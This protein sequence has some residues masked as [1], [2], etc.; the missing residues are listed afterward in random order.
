MCT[1]LESSPQTS[2]LWASPEVLLTMIHLEAEFVDAVDYKA[3]DAY[4]LGCLLVY[5]LTGKAPFGV[6]E[7]EKQKRG[8]T[9]DS[10]ILAV[11]RGK[12]RALVRMLKLAI[13]ICCS[14]NQQSSS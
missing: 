13:E 2:W 4:G 3:Q 11:Y 10:Q 12:Q 5:L 1:G 9:T 8:L 14:P 7:E 6:T